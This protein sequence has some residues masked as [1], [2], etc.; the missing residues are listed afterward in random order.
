MFENKET[1]AG[2]NSY[3]AGADWVVVI[4]APEG[5]NRLESHLLYQSHSKQGNYGQQTDRLAII[6]TGS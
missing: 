4:L 5:T 2:T 1:V 3:S 6:L